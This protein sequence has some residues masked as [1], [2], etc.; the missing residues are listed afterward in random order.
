MFLYN[1]LKV[2]NTNLKETISPLRMD[3]KGVS[4]EIAK[5]QHQA[6]ETKTSC[7][8]LKHNKVWNYNLKHWQSH[9]KTKMTKQEC[10]KPYI[11]HF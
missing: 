9:M 5:T 2:G 8:L 1:S 11:C 10:S 6:N 7:S 3:Y 4:K